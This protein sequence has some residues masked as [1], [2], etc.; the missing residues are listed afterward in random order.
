MKTIGKVLNQ[1]IDQ[2]AE[3]LPQ[4]LI[5]AGGANI[6]QNNLINQD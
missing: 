1:S 6:N 3:W 4:A 2:L 5:K